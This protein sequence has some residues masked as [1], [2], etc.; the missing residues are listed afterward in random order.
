MPITAVI[1]T[2][3]A[4]FAGGAISTAIADLIRQQFAAK[5]GRTTLL[6]SLYA[7][8]D[9]WINNMRD[10]YEETGKGLV[11]QAPF[12][13]PSL[14]RILE[15]GLFSSVKYADLRTLTLSLLRAVNAYNAKYEF[16]VVLQSGHLAVGPML[17]QHAA[18]YAH[19][20]ILPRLQELRNHLRTVIRLNQ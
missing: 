6:Q 10:L 4:A 12:V 20:I 7:E 9:S 17:R 13:I 19:H 15:S 8:A 18:N 5:R 3:V 16:A 1:L 2:L 14:Y 11:A